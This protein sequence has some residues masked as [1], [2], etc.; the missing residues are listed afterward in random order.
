M[1]PTN[2]GGARTHS[3]AW[4]ASGYLWAL[5]PAGRTQ[6]PCYTNVFLHPDGYPRGVR[7]VSALLRSRFRWGGEIGPPHPHGMCRRG[8]PWARLP[9]VRESAALTPPSL[10]LCGRAAFNARGF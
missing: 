3:T 5:A 10:A 1:N 9:V 6:A 4:A 2:T 8:A 7:K